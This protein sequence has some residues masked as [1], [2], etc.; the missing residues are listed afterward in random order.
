[1][2]KELA[3]ESRDLA[4]QAKDI[5]DAVYDLKTVNPNK[6]PVEDKRTHEELIDLN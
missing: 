2:A 1:M 4:A 5:E 3:R 6:E